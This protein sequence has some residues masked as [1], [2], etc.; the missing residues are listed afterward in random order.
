MPSMKVRSAKKTAEKGGRA[1]E[2]ERQCGMCAVDALSVR[3]KWAQGMAGA[4]RKFKRKV[5]L[6]VWKY[7]R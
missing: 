3:E 5:G 7:E 2:G 6:T 4:E 1:K